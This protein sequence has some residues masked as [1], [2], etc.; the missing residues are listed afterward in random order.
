MINRQK[1][2]LEMRRK[3]AILKISENLK[4]NICGTLLS[5][6]DNCLYVLYS[7]I[8]KCHNNTFFIAKL[9]REAT[10]VSQRIFII[11]DINIESTILNIYT[12]HL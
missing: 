9:N 4:E 3:I 1:N 5:Y 11:S 2:R 12:E 10:G 7:F 6:K 8:K